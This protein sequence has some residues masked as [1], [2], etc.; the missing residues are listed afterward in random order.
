M[1]FLEL[2]LEE[3][4]SVVGVAVGMF[5]F[6]AAEI[7]LKHEDVVQGFNKIADIFSRHPHLLTHGNDDIQDGGGVV[8]ALKVDFVKIFF[9]FPRRQTFIDDQ[10]PEIFVKPP[11]SPHSNLYP[12]ISFI[13]ST[14]VCKVLFK[15][16]K[17]TII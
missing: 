12:S 8:A 4:F 2:V 3:V 5:E 16:H 9:F 14:V 17:S 1:I 11:V 15:I 7:Y 13:T 10:L 6:G